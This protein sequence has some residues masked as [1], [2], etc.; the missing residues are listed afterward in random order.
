M[1]RRFAPTPSPGFSR[2]RPLSLARALALAAGLGLS[3]TACGTDSDELAYEERPVEQLYREA[4]SLLEE[5]DYDAAAD[6]FNEVERQHP[7]SVWATKAQLMAAYSHYEDNDYD[8][9]VIALD[10]FIQLHP[11]HRDIAYAHYLKAISYYEQIV[12]VRRDQAITRLAMESLREVINR[13]PDTKYARDARFKIDLARD[14][15]AGKEMS[16]GR[17]YLRE[18]HYLAALN[19]F[20][21]VV[22]QYDQTTHV[23]EALYRIVEIN[24]ILGIEPEAR[25]VAAVLGYN[26]PGSDWYVDAY[27]LVTGERIRDPGEET[28]W[29]DRLFDWI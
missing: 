27:Q 11:G 2:S 3:V 12:D 18:K 9:A 23:A 14:H 13:F 4:V 24:T 26:Y 10:R 15:M 28:R 1:I 25:K 17:F 21:R 5:Q 20:K 7:Y 16:V 8:E 19:R 22:E 6:A 29:Y